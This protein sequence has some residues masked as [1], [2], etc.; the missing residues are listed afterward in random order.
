MIHGSVFS[1]HESRSGMV[2][3]QMVQPRTSSN[4]WPQHL[5]IKLHPKSGLREYRH[6]LQSQKHLQSQRQVWV[7]HPMMHLGSYT[8]DYIHHVVFSECNDG[9]QYVWCVF[10]NH[11]WCQI[12]NHIYIIYIDFKVIQCK[13][14]SDHSLEVPTEP[15]AE[16][17]NDEAGWLYKNLFHPILVNILGFVSGAG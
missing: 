5:E 8:D 17:A 10:L 1:K 15:T 9:E 4:K 14:F 16:V 12:D 6:Y 3:Y 13:A 2:I 11:T 7:E